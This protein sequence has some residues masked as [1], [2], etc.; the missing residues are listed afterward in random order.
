MTN[1]PYEPTSDMRQA[2][3]AMRDLFMALTQEG[4]DERQALTIVGYALSGGAK[5]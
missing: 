2:A 1:Q 5:S 4:F 3:K